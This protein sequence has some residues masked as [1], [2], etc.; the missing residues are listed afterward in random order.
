MEALGKKLDVL[1]KGI[2]GCAETLKDAFS[3]VDCVDALTVKLTH[4]SEKITLQFNTGRLKVNKST[5]VLERKDVLRMMTS[6]DKALK[7]VR[8]LNALPIASCLL[9]CNCLL[10]ASCLFRI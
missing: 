10:I 9:T 2:D 4:K 6:K 7:V 1:S 5:H 3:T 8:K